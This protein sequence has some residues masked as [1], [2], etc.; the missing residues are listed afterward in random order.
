MR[1]GLQEELLLA[2]LAIS[3]ATAVTAT[4]KGD[5]EQVPKPDEQ[6]AA[7]RPRNWLV[8]G[9]SIGVGVGVA[10]AM[11]SQGIEVVSIA[12]VSTN[13]R[14]WSARLSEPIWPSEPTN[15]VI[16]LGT[17]DAQ[18]P[19]LMKEFRTNVAQISQRLSAQGHRLIWILPPS[20]DCVIP[21][22][23]DL[24]FLW[25]LGG[26]WIYNRQLPM[27]DKWHPTAQGYAELARFVLSNSG[28]NSGDNS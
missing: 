5:S 16:S 28:D 21:R 19:E 6:V 1:L 26:V 22:G 18:S 24:E 4:A 27:A 17:N 14:Q 20:P 23:N 8:I 3:L 2:A 10:M 15:V 13:A 11:Q 7:E 12:K 9:D 25:S